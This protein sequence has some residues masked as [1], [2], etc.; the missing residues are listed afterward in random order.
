MFDT[1]KNNVD[2]KESITNDIIKS[3]LESYNKFLSTSWSSWIDEKNFNLVYRDESDGI[4]SIKSETIINRDVKSVF[5]YVSDLKNKQNYDSTFDTGYTHQTLNEYLSILYL[6]HKGVFIVS[7]RD[8]VVYCYKNY[9]EEQAIYLLSSTT[10]EGIPIGNKTVRGVINYAGFLVEKVS[11][12]KSKLTFFSSVDVKLSN[13]LVNT[14][15]K[16]VS[17]CVSKI[18]K[19]LEL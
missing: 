3:L 6:K 16:G 18:K 4:R 12:S 5:D 9:N 13:L 1:I 11:E 10:V 8:F 2:G 7:P 17:F 15:L 19:L 14:S